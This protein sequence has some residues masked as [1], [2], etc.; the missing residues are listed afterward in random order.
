M[1]IINMQYKK[2]KYVGLEHLNNYHLFLRLR[3]PLDYQSDIRHIS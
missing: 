2:K 3:S 1:Y